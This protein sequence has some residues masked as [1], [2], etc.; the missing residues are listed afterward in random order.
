MRRRRNVAGADL[1]SNDAAASGVDTEQ[2]GVD[3]SPMSHGSE[4]R[5]R[6]V[7]IAPSEHSSVGQQRC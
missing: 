4:R 1:A 7:A 3:A 2:A 5:R 6:N